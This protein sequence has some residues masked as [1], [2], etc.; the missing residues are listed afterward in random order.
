MPACL[1]RGIVHGDIDKLCAGTCPDPPHGDPE[2]TAVLKPGA[3]I[4]RRSSVRDQPDGIGARRQH[5]DVPAISSGKRLE[6]TSARLQ[7]QTRMGRDAGPEC[8][9]AERPSA[10]RQFFSNRLHL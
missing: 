7:S 9:T 3:Y 10:S 6:L 1:E 8:W 4:G 5:E 2:A